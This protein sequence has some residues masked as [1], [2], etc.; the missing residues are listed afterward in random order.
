MVFVLLPQV[1]LLDLA[2]PAQVFAT[3][4]QYE[5]S[6]L[7]E[8]TPVPSWQGLPLVADLGW[9]ALGPDDLVIVPG[10]REGYGQISAALLERMPPGVS[11]AAQPVDDES[12]VARPAQSASLVHHDPPS[13]KMTHGAFAP[14]PASA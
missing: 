10:Y 5:L 12:D 9:P 4:E 1:H 13:S 14:A 2:G 8:S 7:A 6:Y 11:L 3:A